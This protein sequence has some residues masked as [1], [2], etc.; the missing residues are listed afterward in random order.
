MLIAKDVIKKNTSSPIVPAVGLVLLTASLYGPGLTQSRGVAGDSFHHLMNGIFVHDAFSD[1]STAFS[2]P[3]EFGKNY[4]RH[5]PAMNLGYYPP[6]FPVLEAVTMGVV[7]VSSFSGQL[8]V[9]VL[10]M[11]MSLF[12][13]AWFRLRLDCWWAFAAA[14]VLVATPTLVYWGRDIMLEIPALAFMLGAMWGFESAI[15]ADKPSWSSCLVCGVCS[16]LAFLTKQ[17]TLLLLGVYG[18]S[19]VTTRRWRHVLNPRV[20]VALSIMGLA[21]AAVI[22]MTLK[23][24]G[25]AVGHTLGLNR[26]HVA[27]RFN[28]D[29]WLHY[30]RWLPKIV[31]WPT[32]VL[33]VVGLVVVIRKKL[34]YTSVLVSWIIIFYLMHSYFRGQTYRYGCL[35]VPPFVLLGAIGL[36]HVARARVEGADGAA[37]A[38]VSPIRGVVLTLWV[39]AT[40]VQGAMIE[41]PIVPLAYQ[42]AADVLS[43]MA[44]PFSCLTFFPDFPG[45]PAV[46]YRLAVEK[47]ITPERPVASFGHILRAGQI[48]NGWRDKWPDLHSLDAALRGWN[49]KYILTETPCPINERAGE[50]LIAEAVD[51]LV[52]GGGFREVGRWPAYW[53]SKSV[54]ERTLILYERRGPMVFSE[55]AAWPLRLARMKFT[56]DPK[57][58]VST[59]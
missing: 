49:V 20:I 1:P 39:G 59:P 8:T 12:A 37:R 19:I 11:S 29:Q 23:V 43:E 9:L 58:K 51:G 7:G 17:H 50:H 32:V 31:T 21:G 2:D 47:K 18:I 53:T 48:L 22:V 46:C 13:F 16:A 14:A 52:S 36:K 35:W 38:T 15:R 34:P 54:P 5:Y 30:L 33:A 4:Y 26:Q 56:L 28:I 57:K 44:P 41:R 25:T 3:L 45:R 40:I 6:V 27:Q 42:Q 55:E 10:A 24:G